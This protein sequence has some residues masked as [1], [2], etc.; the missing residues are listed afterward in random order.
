MGLSMCFDK[1]SAEWMLLEVS[2]YWQKGSY[3]VEDIFHLTKYC[4]F[5]CTLPLEPSN[6]G[7]RRCRPLCAA[8]S[9]PIRMLADKWFQGAHR[10]TTSEAV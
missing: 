7:W 5:T 4:L 3:N 8:Q 6:M 1:R 2:A 9:G 10:I